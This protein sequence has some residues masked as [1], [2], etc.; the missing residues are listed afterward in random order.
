VLKE[1]VVKTFYFSGGSSV[2]DR[3]CREISV[4]VTPTRDT[5]HW[6]V[7]QFEQTGSVGVNVRTDVKSFVLRLYKFR[8]IT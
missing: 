5:V 3:K 6:I 2:V 1:F 8:Y 7:K 4:R